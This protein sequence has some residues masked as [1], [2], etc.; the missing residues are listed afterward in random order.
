MF[1]RA[2]ISKLPKEKFHQFATTIR[3]KSNDSAVISSFSLDSW[4]SL[5]IRF[6]LDNSLP[7][8]EWL[9]ALHFLPGGLIAPPSD[10]IGFS[11]GGIR[12]FAD[13]DPSTER[14]LASWHSARTDSDDGNRRSVNL[15]LST[16]PRCLVQSNRVADNADCAIAWE[17]ECAKTAID[18]NTDFEKSGPMEKIRSLEG[19]MLAWGECYVFSIPA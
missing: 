1:V 17:R 14:V 12:V 19:Q 2:R 15:P 13:N 5:I 10:L 8:A 18:I 9:G 7:L 16:Q 11:S 6:N 4:R 3:L